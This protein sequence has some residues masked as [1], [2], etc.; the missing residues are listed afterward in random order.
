MTVGAIETDYL[1][2]GAG[3][4]AMAFVDTLLDETD[5]SVVMVDRLPRPGGHWNHAYAFVTLHQPSAFY[6][7]GSRELGAWIKDEA[8]PN[9]GQYHLASGP[10]VL[11]YFGEVMEQRFLPSGRV[12][13]LPRCEYV[14]PEDAAG[15]GDGDGLAHRVRSLDGGADLRILVRKKL[16]DATHVQPAVPATHPPRY[17]IA[18]GVTCVP[19][20][21]LPELRDAH[22][23]YTVVGAGKTGIDAC[24]WLLEHGV[25]PDRIRWIMPR[26]PW[27]QDRANAQPGIENFERY[28]QGSLRQYEAL[29]QATSIPDLFARLEAGGVLVRIDP[30]VEPTVYRCGMVS[31]AELAQLRRIEDVVRLGHVRALTPPEIVLERGAV[32]AAPGA[33]Y[34]D[35]SAGGFGFEVAAQGRPPLPVF[36][37]D[38]IN[39]LLVRSCQPLFSAAVIAYVESH[40]SGLAEQNALC[41]VVPTPESPALYPRMWAVTFANLRRWSK[42]P[43]M[44]AWLARCRLNYVTVMLHGATP[45]A[46][47]RLARLSLAMAKASLVAAARIPALLATAAPSGS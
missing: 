35:C 1:V 27:L 36:D 29:A 42:H 17:A 37:G 39:L 32:P 15:E 10:E 19:V 18:P 14:G 21:R 9:A 47:E 26:D 31:Q 41:A 3:A 22:D 28:A 45:E 2:V 11:R 7:V 24:V 43:A 23:R 34:V 40:F 16:V 4:S 46:S 25:A 38:R 6:G 33:L 44:A 5:A 20:N 12:R 13:Y 30:R 8:G